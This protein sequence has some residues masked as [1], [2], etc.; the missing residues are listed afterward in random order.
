MI[1]IIK[2][3]LEDWEIYDEIKGTLLIRHII[4]KIHCI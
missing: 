2:R 1:A 3:T 4:E